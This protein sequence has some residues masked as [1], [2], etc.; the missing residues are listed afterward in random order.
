MARVYTG[1]DIGSAH[2]KVVIAA[3]PANPDL[4]MRILGTGLAPSRGV[5]FG[6]IVDGKE[7]LKSL[8]EA[9][10][11]AQGAAG[12]TV[13]HA[14]LALGS[15]GL[16][17][18][19]ATGE[20]TLTPSGGVVTA[21]EIARAINEGEK[22]TASKLVN[23][24]ILHTFPLEYR[25]DGQKV[26]GRPI[27]LQ[28]T[29]LSVDI[30][31]VV[32][33]SKHRDDAEEVLENAGIEVESVIAS[34]LAASFVTLNKAQKTAGVMLANIGAETVSTIV[35]DNDV[36]I[37][38]KV[39][40][41]G[42]AD[43]TNALA[44]SLKIPLGEAEQLKKGAVTGSSVSSQ[45]MLTV[46]AV[47]LKKIFMDVN[48]HLKTIARQGLLPAGIVLT[49]GGAGLSNATEVA[50]GTLK[51]PATTAQIGYLPRS[52]GLDSVW[53]VAYGL[54]RSAYTEEMEDG[55][56]FTDVAGSAWDS[57]RNAFRALL[58]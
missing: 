17:D 39:F 13:R 4:P 19:R 52:S 10:A 32:T 8:H 35:F 7:A 16:E 38:I 15:A 24:T 11:R 6:Y 5:R 53:A 44:L 27:G 55:R 21:R 3:P 18:I 25:V 28:G 33:P 58:P 37:S 20:I 34:P 30:L 29:K 42:S 22:R 14:R 2:V 54:C 51:L 23:K 41:S 48:V 40:E 31:L 12:M 1:I 56:T 50:R 57:V 45:K 26:L 9:L 49:G 43:I 46:A 47:R 36:P